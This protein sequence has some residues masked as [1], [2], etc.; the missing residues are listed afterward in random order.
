MEDNVAK[1]IILRNMRE[2]RDSL[3][4]RDRMYDAHIKEIAYLLVDE[5][6]RDG[7]DD[8]GSL[9][10]RMREQYLE[11]LSLASPDGMDKDFGVRFCAWAS[12]E[13]VKRKAV[14]DSLPYFGELFGRERVRVSRLPNRLADEAYERFAE[15]IENLTPSIADNIVDVCEEVADSRSELCMLPVYASADGLM[16]TVCRHVIKNGLFPVM[17]CDVPTDDEFFVRFALFSP[18][19]CMTKNADTAVVTVI[20]SDPADVFLLPHAISAYG[21]RSVDIISLASS[22]YEGSR[23][24][25]IIFSVD[26]ADMLKIYVFLAMHF[27]RFEINGICEIIKEEEF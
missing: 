6:C 27:P 7:I 3:E 24:W 12:D 21:G 22:L 17:F 10:D 19:M 26:G 11:F 4:R 13:L 15:R 9:C 23:A 25:Q 20:G 14:R 5:A 1:D 8:L 18:S 2:A 16:H